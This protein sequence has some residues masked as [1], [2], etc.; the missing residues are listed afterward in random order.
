M[1]QDRKHNPVLTPRAR[2]L[3]KNMTKQER[4]LWHDFLRCYPIKILRQ[5]VIGAYIADFYCAKAKLVIELDGDQHFTE[6]SKH[7]DAAREQFMQGFGIK[8]IRYTNSEV[9][10][11]FETV[12]SDIEAHIKDRMRCLSI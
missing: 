8:T 11:Q 6:E 10:K 4:H 12:C 2:E 5:K 1:Q 3:R 7:Y 9:D